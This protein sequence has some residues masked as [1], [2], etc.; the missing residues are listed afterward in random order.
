MY[1]LY[2]YVYINK[3]LTMVYALIWQNTVCIYIHSQMVN[4]DSQSG[5]YV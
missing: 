5:E 1:V 2:V 4:P 3:W